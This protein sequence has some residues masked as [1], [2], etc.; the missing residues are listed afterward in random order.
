MAERFQFTKKALEALQPTDKRVR[1]HDAEVKG[2]TL[3]VEPTGAK[4]F[5]LYKKVHGVPKDIKLGPFPEFPLDAARAEAMRLLAAAH[6]G[7]DPAQAARIP[8]GGHTFEGLFT[9]YIENYAKRRKRSWGADEG[10]YKRY[11]R[12]FGKRYAKHITRAEVRQL[13][14]DIRDGQ[15][16]TC[17]KRKR[18]K[19][20][21]GVYVANRVLALVRAVF[22]KA[23][24]YEVFEG[25]NP[26]IGI[27]MFK[28]QS[29]DRRLMPGEIQ[30]FLRA[31]DAEQNE[32]IKDYVYLS[33]LTG[34]RMN[35]VLAMAWDQIDVASKLWRIP[36]TKNGRP[37]E[38]PLLDAELAIL[39]R[40]YLENSGSL[41]VFPS[42]EKTM[43]GHLTN[44]SRGWHRILKAA[45]IKDL[46]I[47]D[48]RRTLGSWMGDTGGSSKVIGLTLGHMSTQATAIYERLS[49]SPVR[50]AKQRAHDALFGRLEESS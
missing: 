5:Y 44:P 29:R 16:G 39:N 43:T 25:P 46:R 22:N 21:P 42:R 14:A 7:K 12:E 10:T 28:E 38:V 17:V 4:V 31:L 41:W 11:L 50:A 13:H 36:R 27:E 23:I 20:E 18:G 33:L 1:Y 37:L 6:S 15:V 3:R 40:R 48:L 49:L 35:N 26:A 32:D 47:H 19:Q 45:G 30:A 9:W 2:L 24:A 34:Q 8:A